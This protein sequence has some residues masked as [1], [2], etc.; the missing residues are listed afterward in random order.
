MRAKREQKK[1]ALFEVQEDE[2]ENQHNN[3]P[4]GWNPS[5]RNTEGNIGNEIKIKKFK[6]ILIF[7]EC[8]IEKK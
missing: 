6:V 3:I 5:R 8:N 1:A 4:S 2:D 7:F